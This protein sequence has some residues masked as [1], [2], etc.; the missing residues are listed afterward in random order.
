M[1]QEQDFTDP[2]LTLAQLCIQ[3]VLS[4]SLQY[5]PQMTCML[6]FALRVYQNIINKYHHKL[7]KII[8]DTL[9]I[10]FMKKAGAF[11]R[12]KDITVNSYNPYL[13]MNTVSVSRPGGPS[14][15]E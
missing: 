10:K 15:D 7:I 13:V 12:P 8:H 9:F 5:H 11:V 4:Q 2:E 3:L 6:F 1:T 14:A